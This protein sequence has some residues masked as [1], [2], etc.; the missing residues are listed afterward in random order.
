MNLTA[1]TAQEVLD[2]W[3]GPG[4]GPHRGKPRPAWFSKS[5]VFDDEIRARFAGLHA[6]AAQGEHEGWLAAPESGLA[7]VV[8]L[9]QFPRNMYRGTPAAFASDAQALAAAR[10]MVAQGFDVTLRPVE[11][12]FVY[13]PFEHAE[14]LDAQR[15]SM[16]LFAQLADHAESADAID[17]ARRHHEVIARFGRFPHRNAILGRSSTAAEVEFLETRGSAF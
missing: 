10:K 13:L 4:V 17:Y 5:D 11:R 3:F 6:A 9:D 16:R 8:L 2:F 14:D 15:E 1:S 12:W 7:L